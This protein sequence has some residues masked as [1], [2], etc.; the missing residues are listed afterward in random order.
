MQT[1]RNMSGASPVPDFRRCSFKPSFRTSID[2]LL[3]L[4][5][6]DL[7]NIGFA[8]DVSRHKLGVKSPWRLWRYPAFDIPSFLL[9]LC[10][11]TIEDRDSGVPECPKHPPGSRSVLQALS[12][13]NN[14]AIL[15]ADAEIAHVP[16]KFSGAGNHVWQWALFVRDLIDVEKDCAGNVTFTELLDRRRRRGVGHVEGRLYNSHVG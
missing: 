10:Q 7:R 1:P 11:P 5:A 8:A 12:V 2:Q 3:I 4:I 16:G 15:T 14:H 13:I 9:P 6:D